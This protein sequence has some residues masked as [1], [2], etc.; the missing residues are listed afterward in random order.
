MVPTYTVLAPTIL[1]LTILAASILAQS[2][3]PNICTGYNTYPHNIHTG[4]Q[5]ILP[6]IHTAYNSYWPTIHTGTQYIL[7]YN[8][9]C[10]QYI[11]ANN[12]YCL[13]YILV[14]NTYCLQYILVHNPYHHN[15]YHQVGAGHLLL[16]GP[17]PYYPPPAMGVRVSDVWFSSFKYWRLNHFSSP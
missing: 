12:P 10:P 14:D 7:A 1:A 5:S 11:L 3:L 2:I 16:I 6:A 9:Y 8:T 17:G 13:Q 4:T 15:T